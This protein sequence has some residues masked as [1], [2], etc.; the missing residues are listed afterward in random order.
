MQRLSPFKGQ[1]L[2]ELTSCEKDFA[3]WFNYQEES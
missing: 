3:A 2:G 1:A